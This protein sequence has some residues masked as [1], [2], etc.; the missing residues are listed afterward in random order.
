[1]AAVGLPFQGFYDAFQLWLSR[2]DRTVDMM[3]GVV[4]MVVSLLIVKHAWR[5]PSLLAYM[6]AGFALIAVSMVG[7]VW[8][9][10]FDASRALA[11]VF[12]AYVLMVPASRIDDHRLAPE[13]VALGPTG[14]ISV[15]GSTE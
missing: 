12:T 14:A 7:D 3:I 10:Y 13:N 15:S 8:K 11:P 4:L 1:M 5:R 2:P 6:T 9:F